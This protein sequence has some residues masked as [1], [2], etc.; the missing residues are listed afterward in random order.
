MGI[1]P[2]GFKSLSMVHFFAPYYV[3]LWANPQAAGDIAQQHKGLPGKYRV[4]SSSPCSKKKGNPQ[5]VKLNHHWGRGLND[6]GFSTQENVISMQKDYLEHGS[7]KDLGCCFFCR[8]WS[9]RVT[10]WR[11]PVSCLS[12]CCLRRTAA[13]GPG[14]GRELVDW[15]TLGWAHST[16]GQHPL[17]P[18]L[19]PT[20][21]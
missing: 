1:R 17:Q 10:H 15:M 14:Q 3:E 19:W 4:L 6:L 18:T 8:F 16:K 13:S 7:L 9:H 5:A 12:H 11:C 21:K 2:C 20:Y